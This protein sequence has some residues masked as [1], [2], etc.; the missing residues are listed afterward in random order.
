MTSPA[1]FVSKPRHPVTGRRL[2]IRAS[3]ERELAAYLHRIEQLSNDLRLKLTT[4]DEVNRALARLQHGVVTLERAA[5]AYADR[6]NLAGNTRGR[7]LSL[8]ATHFASL[9]PLEF[10]SIDQGALRKWLDKLRARGFAATTI[11][12]SWRTL[13]SIARYASERGWIERA[14]WGDFAPTLWGGRG[15]RPQREACRTLEELARLIR[16]ARELEAEEPRARLGLEAKVAVGGLLGPRQGEL[17]GLRWTDLDD[18]GEAPH[19]TIVRQWDGRILKSRGRRRRLETI[20]DLVEILERY[21]EELKRAGLHAPA[22]PIFPSP[23]LSRVGRPAHYSRGE[24]LTRGDIRAAVAR[25]Q[26]PSVA[27]WS[28]HSLRDTFVTLENQANGGDLARTAQRSGH[29]SIA[30]LARYLRAADRQTAAPGITALPALPGTAAP[31][32]L[33]GRRSHTT[34]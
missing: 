13:R 12:T 1:A 2:Y 23:A 18:S 17:A 3:S 25:A 14:P 5:R 28:A 11:G 31:P 26:L 32:L 22:G 21:R 10:V 29:G 19:V 4:V 20:A 16:A 7:V 34:T 24:V 30:S 15:E 9:A 8:L 6:P 33:V 27:S